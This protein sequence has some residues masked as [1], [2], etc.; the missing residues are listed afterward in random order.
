M[1]EARF[2]FVILDAPNIQVEDF[3]PFYLAAQ[4]SLPCVCNHYYC[5]CA[6]PG[7][8]FRFLSPDMAVGPDL[9]V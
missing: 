2:P 1:E 9:L 8:L 5:A 6:C 7:R 3:K 4:V